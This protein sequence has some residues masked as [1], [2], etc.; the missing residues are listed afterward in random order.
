MT[1]TNEHCPIPSDEVIGRYF[2]EHRAKLIDIAAFLDR[3]ERAG[4]DPDDFRL[5]AMQKAIAQLGISG[6]DRARRV[7]EVFSDP[8][9]QPIETAPMKGALGAFNPQDPS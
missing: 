4:G 6:A 8:T 1:G 5:Q 2:L 7:Q 9:D 3:V